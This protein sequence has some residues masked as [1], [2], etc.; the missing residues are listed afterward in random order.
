MKREQT[1]TQNWSRRLPLLLF[2][3]PLTGLVALT[4]V[5][6]LIPAQGVWQMVLA[7]ALLASVGVTLTVWVLRPFKAYI[8]IVNAMTKRSQELINHTQDQ[9]QTLEE[10]FE[11]IAQ[12]NGSIHLTSHNS[13][14]ADSLSQSTLEAVRSGERL[15]QN[16]L[17]AMEQISASSKQIKDISRVVHEIASQTNL[18][19]INAAVE[20]ARGGENAKGFAIVAAEIKNLAKCSTDSANEIE[21]LIMDNL[22]RVEKGNAVVRQ[23]GEV[24]QQIVTNTEQTSG[25]VADVARAMNLQAVA[26][27]QIE[28]AVKQLNQMTQATASLSTAYTPEEQYG[29]SL[30]ISR[31]ISLSNN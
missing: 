27:Q 6:M 16:T 5:F 2:A 7:G 21:R 23:S 22:D 17:G 4:A 26:L 13:L 11:A 3:I 24:L 1:Q 19:A 8:A 12:V 20:A 15:A 30:G 18:L 9:A 25:V 28:A 14:K 31:Q 10:I 29:A